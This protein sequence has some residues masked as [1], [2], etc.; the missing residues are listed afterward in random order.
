MSLAPPPDTNRPATNPA[1]LGAAGAAGSAGS[2]GRGAGGAQPSLDDVLAEF[3]PSIYRVALSIVRDTQLAEDVVQETL[4]R[5]WQ[6]LDGFR[7]D[8]PLRNWVLRI[9]HNTAV[10]ALRRRRDQSMDPTDMTLEPSRSVSADVE[11]SVQGRVMVGAVWKALE[12]LDETTRAIVVLRELEGMPYEDIAA[13]LELPLPTVRTR[14]FRARR[15]LSATLAE[16]S[17]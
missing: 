16:W 8:S 1:Q 14:L 9:A 3:G 10:S 13:A 17:P 6:H 2:A 7:G 11:R 12:G 4:L 15:A 5:V